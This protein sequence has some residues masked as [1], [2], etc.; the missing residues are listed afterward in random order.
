[1]LEVVSPT[2]MKSWKPRLISYFLLNIVWVTLQDD[3]P[4]LDACLSETAH[5][6]HCGGWGGES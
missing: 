3:N 5:V 4:S 1:M 6:G 2:V